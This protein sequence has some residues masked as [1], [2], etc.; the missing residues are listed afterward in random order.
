[1][2]HG[3][4]LQFF[5]E[6]TLSQYVPG[7]FASDE[8]PEVANDV[9]TELDPSDVMEETSNGATSEDHLLADSVREIYLEQ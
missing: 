9:I 5:V 6:Q 7:I 8:S 4:S 3:G 2:T 1:M